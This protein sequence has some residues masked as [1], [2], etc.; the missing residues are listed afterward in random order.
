MKKFLKRHKLPE[1]T[2]QKTENVNSLK[3]MKLNLIY[4]KIFP[5]RKLHARWLL[6]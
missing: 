4:N 5:Q 1:Q 6:Y 3:Y 2:Q